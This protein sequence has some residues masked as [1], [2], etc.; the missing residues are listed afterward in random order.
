MRNSNSFPL[1]AILGIVCL[2][3]LEASSIEA[4]RPYEMHVTR[5][6]WRSVSYP[7][8]EFL[9]FGQDGKAASQ[10]GTG[11]ND[12]NDLLPAG[13]GRDTTTR[14][15]STCHS[16]EK[17][18]HERHDK[19]RWDEIITDMVS[20]GMDASDDDLEKVSNYLSIHLGSSA[21]TAPPATDQ[22]P[23]R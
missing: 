7:G 2:C 3:S 9:L 6:A 15:C 19:D 23:K 10:D 20:K 14:L 16:V 17:F 18:A 21:R 5:V 13:E 22:T 12:P 11:T 4:K 1:L 8:R